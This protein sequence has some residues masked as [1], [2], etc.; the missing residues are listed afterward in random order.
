MRDLEALLIFADVLECGS[1]TGAAQRLGIAKSSVSKK[2]SA[3]E[4]E[5]GVRLIQ[6][7]TRKLRVTEEGQGL[8]QRCVRIKQ[9]LAEAEQD[10][11]RSSELPTGTVR[12]S[13]PPLIANSRLAGQLPKFL[14]L[15]PELNIE[16][17]LTELQSDL[18]GE[19]FDIALRIGELPDSSLV[20]QR[21]CTIKS[22]LCASPAYLNVRGRLQQP[23]DIEAHN[24]LFWRSPSRA[25]FT[26]LLFQKGSRSYRAR[27]SGNFVST[28]ASSVKE[29]MIN[30]G[31]I[32]LLPDFTVQDEIEAGLLEDLLPDY[33][34]YAI[35]LSMVYP[36]R[37][38]MSAKTRALANFLKEVF[39]D[40]Q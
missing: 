9:E 24:Y 3:L 17:H 23:S 35:P 33:Q 20:A 29:A 11:A 37:E 31:G 14:A 8:Y 16:L 13:A 38:Q 21:L 30:G 10:V 27:I 34:S 15:Y 7:S 6:R 32:S 28:D 12:L 39:A 36:Q 5:L 25:P 18:I 2:V 40:K 19:G 26:Q 4:R 22:I 1:F